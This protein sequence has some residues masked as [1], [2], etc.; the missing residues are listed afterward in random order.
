MCPVMGLPPSAAAVQFSHD[1]V[2]PASATGVPVA[3]GTDGIDSVPV[4]GGSVVE[5]GA[6]VVPGEDG[7]LEGS[8]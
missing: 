3:P 7:T 8:A 5:P 6:V 2:A 1:E 4:P